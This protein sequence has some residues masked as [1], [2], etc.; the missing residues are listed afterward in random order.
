MKEI[1]FEIM[2]DDI[3]GGFVARALGHSI[4]TQADTREQLWR[5][6]REAV[7]CHFDDGELWTIRQ[8]EDYRPGLR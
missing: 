7:V 6:M 2:E 8:P 5:N 1:I 4:V 3:E